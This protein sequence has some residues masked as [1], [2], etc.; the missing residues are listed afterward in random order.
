MKKYSLENLVNTLERE[1]DLVYTLTCKLNDNTSCGYT[2]EVTYPSGRKLSVI[3][4]NDIDIGVTHNYTLAEDDNSIKT[5]AQVTLLPEALNTFKETI[6]A[7]KT[8]ETVLVFEMTE[9]NANNLTNIVLEI[10]SSKG[11]NTVNIK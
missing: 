8:V 3:Y 11:T 2:E 9:A 10:K 6:P 1:Q 4:T 5:I 7:G